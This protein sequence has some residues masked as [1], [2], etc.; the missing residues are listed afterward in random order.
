M[1][2][3]SSRFVAAALVCL[4]AASL[5]LP[6][7]ADA[8]DT[9]YI[10]DTDDLAALAER[11]SYDAWSRDKTVV[12][13]RDIDLGGVDFRPI[14]SFGGVF[15]G[16]GHTISGLSVGSD[17][18]PAGL[19]GTVTASGAVRE[20]N[21]EGSVAPSGSGE[22]VGGIIGVNQG[23]VEG[24]S[25]TG[26]VE[27][28][29]RAGG[30]VGVNASGG[31]INQCGAEGG[32]FGKNM[33]GGVVGANHGE[34]VGCSNRAYV[35]TNTLD[36]SL[37]FDKLDLSPTGALGTLTSPDTYN[38]TVDSGGVAGFSD[39]SILSCH[40]YGSVGYQHIGYNVGGVAG[41]SSGHIASCTNAA[42]VYGRRDVG[43]VVGMAEPHV[44][45][46]ISGSSLA[47]VRQ[48]L[49]TLS[50]TVDKTIAD[51][52]GASDALS[53]RLRSVSGSVSV[54]GDKAL[55]LTDTLASAYDGTIREVN[56]GGALLDNTLESLDAAAKELSAAGEAA[57][58]ALT[59]ID[60][61]GSSAE[62]K[63]AAEDARTA[64]NR[65]KASAETM[66][67]GVKALKAALTVEPWDKSGA[68]KA[69]EQISSARDGAIYA[70]DSLDS[71]AEHLNKAEP[72]GALRGAAASLKNASAELADAL[73][74]TEALLSY[75][76][77]QEKLEFRPINAQAESNAL[78]AAV[79]GVS[80]QL[81]A[82]NRESKSSSDAV[83]ADVRL[84]NRQFTALMNALLDTVEDAQG[85][86]PTSIIEDT[87]DE[88]VD[89]VIAGKVLLCSNGGAV[90]G[91]IDVGGVAGSMLVYN[92]LDPE[93]DTDSVSALLRRRYELQCVLERCTN[94]GDI[95]AKRENVGSVCGSATLGVV[96]GC[97]ACGS[98]TSE[99]GDYVGGVAGCGDS[100]LR[101][102]WAKCAL[103]GG[104][105]V[106]GI[107]GGSRA[108][109]SGLR[110]EDCRSLVEIARGTQYIGAISGGTEGVFTGNRFVSDTLAGVDRVSYEGRAEPVDY[111]TLISESDAPAALRG[112]T[113][114][115][116]AEGKTVKTVPFQYGE[117]FDASVF[118]DI[119]AVE[120]K[121][122]RWDRDEL[123]DL[124]FDATVSAVYARQLTALGC[125]FTRSAA[126][127]A[128]FVEGAFDDAAAFSAEPAVF[129]FDAGSEG[130]WRVLRSW[131]RT[132]LE[133]WQLDLPDGEAHTL[134][135]LPPE[136][137][138]GRLTLYLRGA[139]G[140]WTA[141][142]HGEM[143]SYLTFAAVGDS[144]A[145]TVVS[146]STPWWLWT[147]LAVFL[148]GA[149]AV[150]AQLLLRKRHKAAQTPEEKKR[151]KKLRI[152]LVA[153]V[154]VLGLTVG[155][156]VKL[157]PRISETMGLYRLV[158]NYAERGDLDLSLSLSAELDGT[159]LDAELTLY[160][161]QCEGKTVSCAQWEDVPIW[162]CDGALLLENG[163]AYRA[164]GVVAD[165]SQ[166]L[167]SA[168]ALYRAVDVTMREENGVKTYHASMEGEDARTVLKA[169]LPKAAEL[170]GGAEAVDFDLVVTDGELTSL[171]V[172]WN[173]ANSRMSAELRLLERTGDHTLPQAVR[174]AV[175]S[176]SLADAPE[177]GDGLALL[178]LAW[179][180]G[181]S[182]E[183]LTADVSLKASCGPLLVD[184]TLVWQRS[185]AYS[186]TLSCLSR[187]GSTVYYTDRAACTGGG[188]AISRADA[189][190]AGT[191]ALLRL[192]C[193]AL[194]LGEAE[195]SELSDGRRYTV[196]LDADAM[197]AFANLVA[198]DAR[199][200]G[201]TADSGTVRLDVRRGQLSALSLRVAGSVRV[202]R[203]DVAASVSAQLDFDP[204]AA[205]RAPSAAVLAAL[206]LNEA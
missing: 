182:R 179:T 103:S 194:L 162:F 187:R 101:R 136:G 107:V 73:N 151:R 117:S 188:L 24:C 49:G 48:S 37:S 31:S 192:A 78:Y 193:K 28:E 17:V 32:V 53:S 121:Y 122:A 130:A 156:A 10:N 51:A 173:G 197:A 44:T 150:I 119:P 13:Q 15:E 180:E 19:F 169:L 65:L 124:R 140:R 167:S 11:C 176:G 8:E 75:L 71:A 160:V 161:T 16:G 68:A 64:S 108:E 168:A 79:R 41:R 5:C 131:R 72:S 158:R 36:P 34:V 33:T 189:S 109:G 203:A 95:S 6:A 67:A 63:S 206:G 1:R 21:V 132:I 196:A 110:V 118:P 152:L 55:A 80:D 186:E 113:L 56:R 146:A 175:A 200:L 129:D 58:D 3:K 166:L 82:L 201:L 190:Y 57:D 81:D 92:A 26:T 50:D 90:S 106:G 198:P 83:L 143:G 38:A 76:G 29:K 105:Y 102:C 163:K 25:F 91:D 46:D 54:A 87:S 125:D 178:L 205:F 59:Q 96:R 138:S 177:I 40:N 204:D 2:R 155:A 147:L 202:V 127:P 120:G 69:V 42:T 62:L 89:A 195:C 93:N 115:F 30:V 184:E 98:V 100:I 18:S 20:L 27:G 45:I 74:D 153:L 149:A 43:G 137:V 70:L 88:D 181:A 183:T 159:P 135:Y 134:R 142:E 35:N 126:R 111:E 97:V 14:P 157:A 12:L 148:L 52:S 23:A 133:Q 77:A 139:D 170:A 4:L 123:T 171:L 66:R 85:Y 99:S 199:A 154:A 86:S 39:G 116:V 164:G 172:A 114:R 191:S 22:D 61:A 144:A 60:G 141:A 47:S 94:T 185:R 174:A 165:Y 128:F 104:R 9:I 84:V 112:F 7:L 145:L